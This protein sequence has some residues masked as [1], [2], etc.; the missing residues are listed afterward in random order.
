MFVLRSAEVVVFLLLI[1]HANVT[2]GENCKIETRSVH[3]YLCHISTLFLAQSYL[4]ARYDCGH[5]ASTVTAYAAY[6][7][8][9]REIVADDFS[10]TG[11]Y[12]S[13]HGKAPL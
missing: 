9:L 8:F 1:F 10:R 3:S 2:V 5:R 11:M 4:I 7:T 6:G 12:K 13:M